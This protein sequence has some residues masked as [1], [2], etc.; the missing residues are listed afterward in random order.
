MLLEAGNHNVY[1]GSPGYYEI[2]DYLR[3]HD[4]TLYDIIPSPLDNGQLKEW[5]VIYINKKYYE[6]W[7]N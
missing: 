1:V 2:D 5:D 7:T 4:F 6:D 3:E